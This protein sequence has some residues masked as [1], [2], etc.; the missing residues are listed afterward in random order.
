MALAPLKDV[1]ETRIVI[2]LLEM[3]NAGSKSVEEV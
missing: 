3:E 1:D 2:C